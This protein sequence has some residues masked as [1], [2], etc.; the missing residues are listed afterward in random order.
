M[1]SFNIGAPNELLIHTIDLGLLTPPRNQFA[2]QADSAL[3]REYYQ[4]LP[5][6]RLI[7][8]VYEPQ[9][10]T[11]IVLPSGEKLT[12]FDPGNGGIHRGTMRQQIAK[13]LISHGIDNAN[14][15]I[16]S[17]GGTKE[18]WH[19][20]SAAQI[21][22]HNAI[23][24]YANG[25]QLHG[26]SG[27][28]GM[29]TLKSTLS[30]GRKID[31]STCPEYVHHRPLTGVA[32]TD[33]QAQQVAQY[34]IFNRSQNESLLVIGDSINESSRHRYAQSSR[35]IDV[36]EPVQLADVANAAQAFD[37]TQGINLVDNI[38]AHVS[39]MMTN[40]QRPQ[41]LQRLQTI[42]AGRNRTPI[43]KLESTLLEVVHDGS[44]NSI[45]TALQQLESKRGVKIYRRA[46]FVALKESLSLSISKPDQTISDAASSVR[47][48]LRVRG[49]KRIP[50]RAIGSTLLL[51]GLE[52]DHSL[53]LNADN[54]NAQHLYVAI[55]RG[56]KSIT[57]FSRS[58]LIGP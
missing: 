57:V 15:G 23:G 42:L 30:Q 40:M 17:S 36:I 1:S 35:N 4:Q 7:V 41:T 26:L 48:Q 54:M 52:C 27:G 22:A 2:F 11:E 38:L 13:V 9:H 20:Y 32:H 12:D 51:K 10:L 45:L 44:R 37:S 34:D 28:N 31:L 6:Q 19:P 14:Y 56:A 33:L 55:S 3:H 18:S 24:R 46:A 49:D 53:I 58:N 43:S 39:K 50:Q 47:E 29:V 21:T 8:S 25:V 5:I 16:S